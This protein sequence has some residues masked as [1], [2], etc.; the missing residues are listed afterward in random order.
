MTRRDEGETYLPRLGKVRKS[1]PRVE[2]FGA[3]DEL[4]CFVGLARTAIKDQQIDAVLKKI[5]E[6][7]F[8]V[9][10]YLALENHPLDRVGAIREE[11]EEFAKR[12]ESSLPLLTRFIYPSGVVG[13]SLL[14]V[15]RAVS[16]RAER[17]VVKLAEVEEVDPE[18][19]SYL[20]YLSKF[21]FTLARHVNISS[22]GSEEHWISR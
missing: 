20:N 12:V 21:F 22:G 15:C 2:A 19:I 4:S 17:A 13:S 14:H 5:Q 10:S 6:S 7:L 3:V 9:G 18:V 16:R 1:H 11:L 8:H